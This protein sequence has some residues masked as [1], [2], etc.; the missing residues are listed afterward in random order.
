MA[1]CVATFALGLYGGVFSGGYVTLLT[2]A[3]VALFRM[4]FVEAVSITKLINI[5]SSLIATLVFM[6]RGLIDYRLG[7]LLSVAMFMG[8]SIGGR[9]ALKMSNVW[10]RCVFLL[11]V[12]LLALKILL[13]DVLGKMLLLAG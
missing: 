1:G 7:I 8:A 9:L 4:T 12:V 3:Y 13:Y 11:A 2:A 6:W 5:F 10:L